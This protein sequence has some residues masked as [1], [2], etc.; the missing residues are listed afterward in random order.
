LVPEAPESGSGGVHDVDL[1]LPDDEHYELGCVIN[2]A[3]Y[4]E[5]EHDPP[6][7]MFSGTFI[8]DKAGRPF[9]STEARERPGAQQGFAFDASAVDFTALLEVFGVLSLK[10]IQHEPIEAIR[11]KPPLGIATPILGFRNPK[12]V[13]EWRP[14]RPTPAGRLHTALSELVAHKRRIFAARA[15]GELEHP[16]VGLGSYIW[17]EIEKAAEAYEAEQHV[18]LDGLVL[19][20]SAFQ[21]KE[22][23]RYLMTVTVPRGASAI[24]YE[25]VH[26][27]VRW[28]ADA[29]G[30]SIQTMI[31][32]AGTEATVGV[33]NS[34]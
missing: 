6:L 7:A 2:P 19:S 22:G 32:P 20:A 29:A 15:A 10:S 31:L 21:F 9:A 13:K 23:G 11:A 12:T 8:E 4:L 30:V 1:S 27:W 3:V 5:D 25:R 26:E 18:L 24:D 16:Y 14:R 17:E 33:A 28:I 34:S